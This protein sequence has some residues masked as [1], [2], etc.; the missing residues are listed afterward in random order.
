MKP[1]VLVL[2]RVL[3]VVGIVLFAGAAG[4]AAFAQAARA[5]LAPG[6]VVLMRH[7]LAP[8][9]GDPEHFTLNDCSTQRN[10]SAQGREQAVRI[11][12][13]FRQLPVPVEAVWSS[14][15]CRT[16]D[17]AD[18]AFPGRRVDQP[19]FNSFFGEPDAAPAQ[20]RAAQALLNGWAGQGLL[21]VVTH[22]VNIT[23]ITGV[24]PA[25]GEAVVLGRR[26]GAWAVTGRLTP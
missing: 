26:A 25:S 13:F 23:A 1:L 8:G 18:L 20:T 7:A 19:A 15:W 10:L 5:E 16:R 2:V 3:R 21:V 9:V 4:C 11:G 6:S 14:Q 22:Q 17:T 12:A 24:V